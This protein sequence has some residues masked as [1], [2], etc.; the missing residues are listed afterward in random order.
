MTCARVFIPIMF[1]IAVPSVGLGQTEASDIGFDDA[2]LSW[3][4][5]GNVQT[6]LES[7]D[8]GLLAALPFEL[9]HLRSD[10]T[11]YVNC[12]TTTASLVDEIDSRSPTATTPLRVEIGP[13][14]FGP[15]HCS[16]YGSVGHIFS[17]VTFAGVSRSLSTLQGVF[18]E[19]CDELH[20]ERLRVTSDGGGGLNDVLGY[21]VWWFHGGTSRWY[22]VAIE[23]T[24]FA[25][26][27]Q[28]GAPFENVDPG[29][30]QSQHY[31]YDSRVS[32]PKGIFSQCSEMWMFAGEV[33]TSEV[34]IDV[35]LRGDVRIFGSAIGVKVAPGA[36]P[37]QVAGLRVGL[38]SNNSKWP[39]VN[40][41]GLGTLHIHGSN[42]AVD[43]SA[44]QYGG[45]VVGLD[46]YVGGAVTA[47][48]PETSFRIVSSPASGSTTYRVRGADAASP[49]LWQAG[50]LPPTSSSEANS[51]SGERG[52]DL[53]V[54]TD[55]A[56][57]GDCDD[58]GLE[59]HLM[60]L[61]PDT[62][63]AQG[64]WLNVVTGKCR[65]DTSAC[66]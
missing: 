33:A 12:F 47:H 61:S 65:T 41:L 45:A 32:G 9:L 13:G 15:L 19:N 53:F 23:G 6:A 2:G 58:G 59:A 1:L 63:G 7:V 54:E 55:C 26:Y 51:L 17:H 11:E 30:P 35:S 28:C 27:E 21:G 39:E 10:C 40:P 29:S 48:T 18:A 5:G 24:N 57:C 3:T 52:F 56:R 34:A 14:T 42:V 37:P 62:C 31:F 50:P 66:P 64:G 25:V 43:A 60:I 16:T 22:D 44:G 20:F 36:S 8:A 49:F 46:V 4:L 38:N